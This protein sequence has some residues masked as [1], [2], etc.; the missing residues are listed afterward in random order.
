MASPTTTPPATAP[1][2][3][4][5]RDDASGDGGFAD[6]VDCA[7]DEKGS[8]GDPASFTV[9]GGAQE[10]EALAYNLL[11]ACFRTDPSTEEA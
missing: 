9:L 8:T 3:L 11:G 7:D 4:S 5:L 2:S 1:T 6:F 10:A